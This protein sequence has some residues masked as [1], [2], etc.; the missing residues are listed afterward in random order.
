MFNRAS[1][2]LA[3]RSVSLLAKRSDA[4]LLS[5]SRCSSSAAP[6]EIA[7]DA[8]DK[9]CYREINFKILDTATVYEAVQQFSAYNIGALVTVDEAGKHN[10]YD[11][12]GW[13]SKKDLELRCGHADIS[14][15]NRAALVNS[16]CHVVFFPFAI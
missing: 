3:R 1:T 8:W 15:Y 4:P 12:R 11:C 7:R 9:S 13:R 6:G 2:I 5:L 14:S 10:C 16:I